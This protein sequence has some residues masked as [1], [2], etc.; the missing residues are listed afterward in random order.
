MSLLLCVFSGWLAD[1]PNC[2]CA[3][4]LYA[5]EM[6]GWRNRHWLTNKR[7]LQRISLERRV[8]PISNNKLTLEQLSVIHLDYCLKENLG[9]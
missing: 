3:H 5:K 4:L 9:S 2:M 8:V 7:K 1:A 6:D